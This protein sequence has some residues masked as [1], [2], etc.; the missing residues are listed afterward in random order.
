MN[1]IK[2]KNEFSEVDLMKGADT[3]KIAV[4]ESIIKVDFF[5]NKM[6]IIMCYL[7]IRTKEV[8]EEKDIKKDKLIEFYN[9]LR[10]EINLL[11]NSRLVESFHNA[12]AGTLRTFLSL[13]VTTDKLIK[14]NIN[15]SMPINSILALITVQE[16]LII[17]Q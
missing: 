13:K 7:D 3:V 4:E 17:L 11:Y 12:Q 6:L 14:Y 2:I 8:A 9:F 10:E 16:N 15:F 5:K 1:E